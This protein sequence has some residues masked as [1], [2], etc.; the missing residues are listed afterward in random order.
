MIRNV[1]RDGYGN[2][3]YGEM[4]K[5]MEHSFETGFCGRTPSISMNQCL[6]HQERW[7]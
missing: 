5:H 7:I 2:A 1:I 4:D 6:S 3:N